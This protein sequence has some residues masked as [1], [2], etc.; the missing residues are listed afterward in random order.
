MSIE[1]RERL[2]HQQSELVFAL[3]GQRPPPAAFDPE[4][5]LAAARSLAVKRRRSVARAWPGLAASLGER[6][7]AYFDD[8]AGAIPLPS[9]GGPLADGRAFLRWLPTSEQSD[10]IRI[11]VL[12]VD[13][14]FVSTAADL[15][16]RLGPALKALVLRRARHLVLGLR[17]PGFGIYRWRLPFGI[18]AALR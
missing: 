17:L 4:Q 13:L 2:A 12:T 7:A 6:F 10:A 8:Y 3:A 1:A 18:R 11:E 9:R 5:V 16:P 14:R 15:R